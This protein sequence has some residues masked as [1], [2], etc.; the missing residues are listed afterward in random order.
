MTHATEK[1]K[2]DYAEYAANQIKTDVFL[3]KF[4]KE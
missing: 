1:V 4:Q 3:R 2:Q